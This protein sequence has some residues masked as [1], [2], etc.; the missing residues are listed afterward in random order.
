[1]QHNVGRLNISYLVQMQWEKAFEKIIRLN[2][3][4]QS[5]LECDQVVMLTEGAKPGTPH[6]TPR[7]IYPDGIDLFIEVVSS[8]DHLVIIEL[9]ANL[10]SFCC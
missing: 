3:R 8:T 9:K 1:M 4:T 7:K 6:I 10:F 2:I 5:N